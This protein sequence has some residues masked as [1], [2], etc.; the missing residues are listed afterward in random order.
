MST[1]K[2]ES[3]D[4]RIAGAADSRRLL[5]ARSSSK[6]QASSERDVIRRFNS[7]AK[8]YAEKYAAS[9]ETALAKLQS[10]GIVKADGRLTKNYK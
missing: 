3:V 9:P 2:I 5:V 8:A 10:L 7:M 6:G 4:L 1:R